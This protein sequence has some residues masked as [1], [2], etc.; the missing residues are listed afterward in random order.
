MKEYDY[1]FLCDSNRRFVNTKLLCPNS[2]VKVITCG[3]S[4][5]AV[6]ILSSPRFQVNKALIINAGVNDVE[7]LTID[8]VKQK[9]VE[10]L[11]V[12]RKAFPG[13][14]IIFSSITPRDDDLDENIRV[15]NRT[16]QSEISYFNDV[17]HV[18][19][20][21]LRNREL[22]FDRKHLNRS[23]GIRVF[24]ANIKRAIRM[25]SGAIKN[26]TRYSPYHSDDQHP[27]RPSDRAANPRPRYGNSVS[28]APPRPEDA[29]RKQCD[30]TKATKVSE[31]MEQRKI[32]ESMTSFLS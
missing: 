32:M 1:V 30:V 21:N 6:K 25:A 4:S 5:Q 31:E 20:D 23:R 17:I 18:N 22:Y 7:H 12:A 27:I 16:V 15:T 8:E 9:Q 10:I 29:L 13:R 19:N 11:Y 24:A 2:T 28:H 14:K 3:T 26:K